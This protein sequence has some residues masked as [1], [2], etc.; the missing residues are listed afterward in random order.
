M[1]RFVSWLIVTLFSITSCSKASCRLLVFSLADCV[2][3]AQLLQE[4]Q[5]KSVT[6]LT[7]HSSTKPMSFEV[8]TMAL[9]L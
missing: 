9:A 1:T 7:S 8:L 3:T 5:R 6:S 2:Q 4:S